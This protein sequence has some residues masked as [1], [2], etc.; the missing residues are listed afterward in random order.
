MQN[1]EGGESG[2]LIGDH[3]NSRC[4]MQAQ[5]KGE[6]LNFDDYVFRVCPML[7]YRYANEFEAI[8][9]RQRAMKQ[10]KANSGSNLLSRQMSMG[11]GEKFMMLRY[12]C[13]LC[14][15]VLFLFFIFLLS[16]VIII[17]PP[18]PSCC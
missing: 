13:I 2:Y 17:T 18:P 11:S 15:V 3:A 8:Q 16:N 14:N 9:S 12:Q 10:K 1:V 4:G 6:A 5:G 7:S